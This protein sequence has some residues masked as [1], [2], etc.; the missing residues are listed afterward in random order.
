MS[1]YSEG[2]TV[3]PVLSEGSVHVQ[4]LPFSVLISGLCVQKMQLQFAGSRSDQMCE[5]AVAAKMQFQ[6]A[7]SR[8]HCANMQLREDAVAVS[9]F[10]A[11]VLSCNV[12]CM[13]RSGSVQ[14]LPSAEVITPLWL[15]AFLRTCAMDDWLNGST[16]QAPQI[17]A[18]M[19]LVG[20]TGKD[21]GQPLTYYFAWYSAV[22]QRWHRWI[23]EGMCPRQ[24]VH[25]AVAAAMNSGEERAWWAN[26]PHQ[27]AMGLVAAG[28]V[29]ALLVVTSR[30]G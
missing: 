29:A 5:D 27:W 24:C 10:R 16:E 17:G 23:I 19:M 21:G 14:I 25:S 18:P 26:A 11:F 1:C 6:F 30:R 3:R 7:A 9:V 13:L 28:L 20:Y 22:N 2:A 4:I 15:R 12:K 8:A